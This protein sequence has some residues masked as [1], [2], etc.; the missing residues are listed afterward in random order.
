MREQ[1]AVEPGED[2][3]VA[4]PG[5]TRRQIRLAESWEKGAREDQN[6]AA[7]AVPSLD[8]LDTAIVR[9]LERDGRMSVLE[10]TRQVGASRPTVTERLARLVERGVIS[11]FHA[12]ADY[13]WLD[14]PITAFI[15]L[16]STQSGLG[17][18]I[19]AS[20]KQIPEVE[21]LYTV[22]GRYDLLVKI[23]AHSPEHLQ[24]IIVFK[25]QSIPGIGR[26]E[27]MLAL[28]THLEWAPV[29]QVR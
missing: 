14:Y 19:I 13:R 15:G 24:H 11:G 29:G 4:E 8:P 10:L 26:G 28:G 17:V 20:L 22:T 16:E 12:R 1:G 2:G 23:R 7:F 18:E 3:R 27:T 25:V 5:A 21:E 9:A 6:F